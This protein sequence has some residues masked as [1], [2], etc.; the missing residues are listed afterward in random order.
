MGSFGIVGANLVGDS[1]VCQVGERGRSRLAIAGRAASIAPTRGGDRGRNGRLRVRRERRLAA[2]KAVLSKAPGGAAS[3][4][5]E[6]V[7]DPAPQPREVVVRVAAC[8]VNFPDSLIIEDKYQ[9]RPPRPFSP[10][11]EV[12]GVIES[13]RRRGRGLEGRRARARFAGLG[14][15]G[16]EGRGR[17]VAR[18]RRFPTRCRSTRRRRCC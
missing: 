12:A 3:L 5:L 8:G 9:I 14:R 16:R 2:M 1:R 7:A 6:E 18:H 11:G 10:G 13:R 17:C 4:V 15:H